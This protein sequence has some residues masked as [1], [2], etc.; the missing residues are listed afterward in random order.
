M[1]DSKGKPS[2]VSDYIENAPAEAR[3]RMQELLECLRGVAPDAEEGL[4]WGNPTF[5]QK[6]V[7][8]SFALYKDHINFYPTPAVIEAFKDKL[9]T[10]KTTS[11]GVQLP[12]DKPISKE[13]ISKL[14]RY[15]LKEVVEN[16]AKWM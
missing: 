10:H 2:T 4:K 3:E 11:G 5:T 7:L 13:L 12:F 16:D 14:V 8:L 15:R 6:R 1:S 9:A